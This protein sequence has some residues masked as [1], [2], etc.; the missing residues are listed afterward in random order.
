MAPGLKPFGDIV[1][2]Q[3]RNHCN[4]IANACKSN[5]LGDLNR[6]W[7]VDDGAY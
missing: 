5:G 3:G 2:G 7:R 4:F 1:H 6:P